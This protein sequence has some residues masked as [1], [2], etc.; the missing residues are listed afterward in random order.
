MDGYP[1]PARRDLWSERSLVGSLYRLGT[2]WLFGVVPAFVFVSGLVVAITS[3][4]YAFDFKQ[5][6]TGAHAVVHGHSPYP[7]HQLLETSRDS[8]GPVGIQ[9]VFRFPYPA[10]TAVALTPFGALPFQI[11][12]AIEVSLLV[13]A[14]VAGLWIVGVRDWR[15]YGVVFATVTVESAVRLGT[16]TPV[17]LLLLAV[18]WRYRDRRWVAASALALAIVSKLFLWPLVLWLA[19]TRRYAAAALS[20]GLAVVLVL[21]G[22]AVIGFDGMTSYPELVRRLNDVVGERGYSLVAFG[23]QSG[24][25]SRT[26]TLLPL[27]VGLPVLALCV[28][29]ARRRGGDANAF[30]V[31]LLAS[32]LLTPIVWNHYFVLLLLPLAIAWPRLSW[33]WLLPLLYW[34]VPFQENEGALWRVVFGLG[35]AVTT[36]AVCAMGE[37]SL[38]ERTARPIEATA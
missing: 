16:L 2:M 23:S 38:G 8:L 25:T 11:A 3:T 14:V 10:I 31:A 37:R 21:V 17:L 29:V 18:G 30:S 28:L 33:A 20:A 1:A 5:F 15:I 26:S 9:H 12:A 6:W 4:D 19:A 36:V 32:L 7:A 34:I 22:W 13:V 27:A 35:L 24:L